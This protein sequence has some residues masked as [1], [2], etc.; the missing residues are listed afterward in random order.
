MSKLRHVVNLS[1]FLFA[2]W[3]A[4]SGHYTALLLVLAQRGET[5]SPAYVQG[6][7]GAAFRVAGP[8]PCAPTAIC[9]G[10]SRN[11]AAAI[12]AS[13]KKTGTHCAAGQPAKQPAAS[14]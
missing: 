11:A 14:K 3:L 5:Y 12:Q 4:L 7:A 6:I 8:C 10:R 2:V 9:A 13:Q 1:L